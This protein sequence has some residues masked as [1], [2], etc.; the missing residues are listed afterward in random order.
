MYISKYNN[1][2]V[3][4]KDTREELEQALQFI[5]YDTI[6]E[7]DVEYV[8]YEGAYMTKEEVEDKKHKDFL[9]D[10]FKTSLGWV[11]RKV[12]MKTGET[13]DFL[14]DILPILQE[15]IP[16]ITY[17]EDGKQNKVLTTAEFIEECKQQVI[18]DFYGA[19]EEL[20]NED[21]TDKTDN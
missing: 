6:E 2:I 5:M 16:I 8:L 4:A 17:T 7:T 19:Q 14:A 21:T 20:A 11:R 15:G 9:K 18:K 1:L 13:K 12:S 10:F 3:L